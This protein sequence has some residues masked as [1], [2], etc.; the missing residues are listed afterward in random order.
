M[1]NIIYIGDF[2]A[3]YSTERYIANAFTELGY[4]VT[5][6]QE[7]RMMIN[8]AQTMFEE[9][10]S[11]SPYLV[12]FSK[13][14][15]LG[16]SKKFIE[17][18]KKNGIKTAVWLFDLYFDLPADRKFRLEQK[19]A[20]FNAEIIF[21]TDGG[22]QKEFEALG[23]NHKLLRQGIYEP[24]SIM[25]DLPKD[26]DVIFV[27][28]DFYKT[29]RMMLEALYERYRERFS[30]YGIPG[31]IVRGLPLNELYG[32]T[33]VVVGD[34]QPSPHYW[35]NRI[36]ETLGRGGFLLHPMVAGLDTEFEIGKHLVTYEYGNMD[37][38]FAKIDYYLEHED[39]REAIRKAG[40]EHVKKHYTYKKRCEALLKML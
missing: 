10:K 1:K 8:D 24:E 38:L 21:S 9:V 15:L 4:N 29:R 33:K 26:K 25:Y 40:F 2:V 17:L 13:G 30:R 28:G 16:E 18:L 6:I 32:S 12:L 27:G 5:R 14:K 19:D 22:H 7:N 20:P 37:D 36:Y 31:K 23:I 34:S 3:T 35:S 39:E 11:M